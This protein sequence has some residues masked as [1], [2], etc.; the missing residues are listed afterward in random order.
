M[1]ERN[2]QSV[3]VE[4]SDDNEEICDG[5]Y[6]SRSCRVYVHATAPCSA[7]ALAQAHPTMSCIR[8]VAR[9]QYIVVGGLWWHIIS[10]CLA[11]IVRLAYH[12]SPS[13][14]VSFVAGLLHVLRVD[15]SLLMYFFCYRAMCCSM[16]VPSST[17]LNCNSMT[18]VQFHT[19]CVILHELDLQYGVT[20]WHSSTTNSVGHAHEHD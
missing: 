16:C 7:R 20:S 6:V 14:L 8:L 2:V 17:S 19:L 10:S 12:F 4:D 5:M 11:Q 3:F 13:L 18:S 15:H 1:M 9:W